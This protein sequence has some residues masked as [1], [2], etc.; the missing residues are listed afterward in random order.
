MQLTLKNGKGDKVHL[1]SDGEYFLT[2]DSGYL[3]ELGL[4]SGMVVSESE[5]E[6]LKEKICSR[7]AYNKAV[8]LLSRRDHSKKELVEKLRQKGHGEYALQATEKLEDYG[9]L[10]DRRFAHSFA[11]EL[12]RLKAY[13]KKRIEQELYRKGIDRDII[14]EVISECDFSSER[15]TEL[16]ERKYSRY[17]SDEKGINKTVNALLRFGYSYSEIRDA[18]KDITDREEFDLADE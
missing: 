7:R 1:L 15:L 14:S 16:I 3:A 10:D 5:A 9:Y 2:V 18:I 17:L 4:Y 6:A 8:D 12:I 13:G 11:Q